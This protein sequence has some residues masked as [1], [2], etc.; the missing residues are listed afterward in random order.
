MEFKQFVD[1]I[2]ERIPEYLLQ[3]DIEKIHIEEV[4]KNNGIK[5]T[6]MVIILKGEAVSP[7]IYLDYYFMQYK[8]GVALEAIFD[9][10]SGEY[11]SAR[12]EM[13]F[14]KFPTMEEKDAKE[15]IFI[16]LVNYERNEKI[17]EDCPYIPFLDLAITFRYL[18]NKDENGIASALIHNKDMERWEM[19]TEELYLVAKENTRRIFPPSLRR[20]EERLKEEIPS[21]DDIFDIG[22]YVLTNEQGINGAA[23]MIDKDIIDGFAEERKSSLFI[24]PSSIHEVL[25]LPVGEGMRKEDLEELVKDVNKYVVSEMDFL[26]NHV[27]YYDI[28]KKSIQI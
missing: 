13:K 7:N 2:V 9:M 5:C 17:L 26:S 16:K 6:G 10:I 27:Y 1:L 15:R 25:L 14:V 22:L 20:L 4:S 12:E 19:N 21:C 8:R 28:S 3:Y 18:A 23:Y 24:L 11:K